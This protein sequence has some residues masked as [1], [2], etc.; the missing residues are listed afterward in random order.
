MF[1]E[2]DLHFLEDLKRF[3]KVKQYGSM[4]TENYYLTVNSLK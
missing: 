4:K 1:Y 2:V 3:L